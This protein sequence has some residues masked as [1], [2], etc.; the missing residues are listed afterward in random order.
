MVQGNILAFTVSHW[1]I[2]SQT[3][4]LAGGIAAVVVVATRTKQRWLVSI[5]LGVT[6]AVVDFFVHPG[7][8]GP[9]FMEAA[10]TGL[11]AAILSYVLGGAYWFWR[12][13]HSTAG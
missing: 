4:L 2:A 11:A 10:V 8:F 1:L 13:K 5:L 7:G 9:I 6:T 12:R 3:G